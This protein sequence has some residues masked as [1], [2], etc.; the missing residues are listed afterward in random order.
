MKTTGKILLATIVAGIGLAMATPA[1]A[2]W[3]DRYHHWHHGHVP[4]GYV[5]SPRYHYYYNPG[6]AY[7]PPPVVVT[8]P[9]QVVYAAPQPYYAPAPYYEPAPVGV[10]LGVHIR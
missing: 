6:Y 9:P 8:P 2:D 10:S 4:Y 3:D 7:A 5:W 1:H